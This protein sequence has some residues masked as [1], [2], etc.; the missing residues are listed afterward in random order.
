[1][2]KLSRSYLSALSL[3]TLLLIAASAFAQEAPGLTLQFKQN[4]ETV[5]NFPLLCSAV[6]EGA[7]TLEQED[8]VEAAPSLRLDCSKFTG[9]V[10]G[11]GHYIHPSEHEA[12]RGKSV[13]FRGMLKWLSGT[14]RLQLQMRASGEKIDGA[15]S[16]AAYWE[17]PRGEWTPFELQ[18]TIPPMSDVQ[19]INFMVWLENSPDPAVVLL[20]QTRIEADATAAQ[21]QETPGAISGGFAAYAAEPAEA[22]LPIITDGRPVATIVIEENASETVKYAVEEL[23]DHL[24]RS[25]GARLDVAVG[26]APD[27]PTIHIGRAA[28]T[29]SLGLAPEYFSKNH[30]MVRRVGDALILTGGDNDHNLHP[31]RGSH[32]SYGT[33]YAT[34]EFLERVVGVRWYWPGEL[35]LVVPQHNSIEVG[36][37]FWRGEPSYEFRSAFYNRPNDPDI[38]S[39]ENYQWWRRMRWGGDGGSPIG[40][41]SYNDWPERFGDEHPEWF[42]LQHNGQRANKDPRG[43]VCFSNPEVFDQTVRDLRA[44]LDEHPERRFVTVM[45]GDGPFECQ[46]EQCKPQADLTVDPRGK[47]SNYVWAFVNRVA[48]EVRKTHPDAVVTCCAYSQY[49]DVPN[50]VALLPNL[51]VTM[52]TNYMPYVWQPDTKRNYLDEIGPWSQQTDSIY[53]WDYW[54]A[55]RHAGV[56]GAPSI[57]PRA[58]KEWFALDAG[59][60]KGRVIELENIYADGTV[61]HDWANWMYDILDVYVAMRLMWDLDQDVEQMLDQYFT[62]LYGPAA[63]LV[64]KFYAELETAWSRPRADSTWDWSVAWLEMYPPE[65]VAR[66]MGYLREA[67]VLTRGQDPWHARV[68]KTL[69]GFLPFEE[70]S[71]RYSGGAAAGVQNEEIAVPVA[72][73]APTVDG[74]LDDACWQSAAVAEGFVDRFNSPDLLAATTMLVTRDADCLYVAMR[75]QLPGDEIKETI[76]ADSRDRHVWEDESCEVFIVAEDRFYQFLLGPRNIFGDAHSPDVNETFDM[77]MFGW[78]AEGAEY[79]TV[80]GDGEWTAELAIPLTSLELAAPTEDAPWRVNFCRNYY[81]RVPEHAEWQWETSAWRPPFGNFHNIERF[82]AMIFAGE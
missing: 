43:W 76:P 34:Y 5:G 22:P 38:T 57:C 10:I 73:A 67:E 55:R 37:V 56:H 25:T 20:D 61:S 30:W 29:E 63:P 50:D 2:N 78:N 19:H 14:G 81:Y 82:G 12:W 33:L 7:V 24:E 48:A 74:Q 17:G 53:V 72:A 26:Q 54:L 6:E 41:H 68:E 60:V 23:N 71:R 13:T 65:L 32:E 31:L 16:T 4:Y 28:L 47:W 79:Q 80:M 62:D 39:E 52:C 8:F 66:T 3:L 51:A 35:G 46:C 27:G 75:A 21:A 42:A 69:T 15:I 45:P 77:T 59:R 9:R 40:M 58:H 18:A 64:E 44:R 36:D 11:V 70:C 1:M 49:R